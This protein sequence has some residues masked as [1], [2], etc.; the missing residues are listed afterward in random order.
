METKPPVQGDGCLLSEPG[1]LTLRP[2]RLLAM[3]RIGPYG[4]LGPPAFDGTPSEWSPLIDAAR[5]LKLI[6]RPLGVVISYDN[7]YLTPPHL[8]QL[9]ACVPLI[10]DQ[11]SPDTP[12][13]RVIA[14]SEV[15][16]TA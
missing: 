15:A 11:M 12:Q 8:Q 3:R 13:A 14:F 10:G 7:P 6:H 16:S 5:R 9:D 2:M 4:T 1:Y